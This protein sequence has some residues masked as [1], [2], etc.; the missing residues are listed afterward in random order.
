LLRHPIIHFLQ[1]YSLI[2]FFFEYLI[3][4]LLSW[5]I[6]V[7]RYLVQCVMFQNSILLS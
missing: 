7:F 1:A 6:S 5:S 4:T 2:Y 3:Q